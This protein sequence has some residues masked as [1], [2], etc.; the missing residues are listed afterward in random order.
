[1]LPRNRSPDVTVS[2]LRRWDIRHLCQKF[3]EEEL[4]LGQI[5]LFIELCG[6]GNEAVDGKLCALYVHFEPVNKERLY[7]DE[8]E[9]PHIVYATDENNKGSRG[10]KLWWDIAFADDIICPVHVIPDFADENNRKAF[11]DTYPVTY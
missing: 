4:L 10:R 6:T 9:E 5:Y 3:S 7:H 1:M 2:E 8:I 11:I